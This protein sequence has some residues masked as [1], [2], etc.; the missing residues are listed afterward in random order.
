MKRIAL[1]IIF[2]SLLFPPNAARGGYETWTAEGGPFGGRIHMLYAPD[3]G[4]RTLFAGTEKG[5][6]F[7][8]TGDGNGWET[9]NNDLFL[10]DVLAIV[11][12]PTEG[13]SMFAGTGGGGVYRS[14]NGGRSWFPVNNGLDNLTITDLE[15]E[16]AGGRLFAATGGG[17]VFY[18]DDRGASW[19]PSNTGLTELS[20]NCLTRAPSDPGIWYVGTGAGVFRSDD[21]CASWTERSGGLVYSN[22]A[23][24]AIDPG[25]PDLVY[26]ASYGGG[27]Y[28]TNDGGSIWTW[29]AAGMGNTNVKEIVIRPD[30]PDT[31]WAAANTGVF[32]TFNGGVTWSPRTS[33]L[34]DTLAQALLFLS[35][36]LYTGTYW[37]G[38]YASSEPAAGWV[39]QNDGM[40]NRFVW[41]VTVSPHDPGTL[42]TASYGG[43]SVSVDTGWTWTESSAGIDA[44]DLR[45]V[46]V[47]PADGDDLLAGVFYGGV[48]AST[49]GGATWT[50]SSSGVGTEATVTTIRYRPGSGSVI[51]CGTYSGVYKS[52]NGGASWYA[53][54]TG[55]GAKNVWG[56]ATVES[57][58][59]LVYAGTYDSGLYRSRDFGETWEEVPLDD[60]F[61]RG[62]AIDP[63]DTSVV[64]AGGYYVQNG[65]GGVYKSVDSGDSWTKKNSGLDNK[66]VWCITIDPADNSHLFTS[67]GDGVFESWDAADTWE[68]I[69]DGLVHTDVRWVAVTGERI[70]AGSYGASAPWLEHA[71]VGV[72]EGTGSYLPPVVPF[73]ITAGPNPFNPST[74]LRIRSEAYESPVVISVYDMGGRLVRLLFEGP[75]SDDGDLR[76]PWDG[77]NGRGVPAS[78]GLYFGVARS[79]AGTGSV[80]MLLIR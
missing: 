71:V 45:T 26:A 25:D 67:T 16:D 6:I 4:E 3:G 49:D 57:A 72:A 31:L 50:S 43:V 18:T 20:L 21:T 75:L 13:D 42:W 10:T 66:S 14:A 58:P 48:Y 32:E 33:G 54:T 41:E 53:S 12:S 64:Y 2:L 74:T 70:V 5:G 79:S 76:V 15:F 23:D 27:V 40:I 8:S 63:S 69:S 68:E 52:V 11:A 29:H 61:I 30:R 9:C 37:G 56:M 73:T 1:A 38:V 78:S 44:F 65:R 80:K 36:T 24:L 34:T 51:L 46:A 19:Q 7:R 55:M 47:S 60:D 17:G 77:T 35:D 62:I 59:D 22:T 28:R 39:A